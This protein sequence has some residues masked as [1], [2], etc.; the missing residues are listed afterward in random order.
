[1]G[2]ER[3]PV[4]PV[5]KLV[6]PVILGPRIVT[7]KAEIEVTANF[8]GRRFGEAADS[9]SQAVSQVEPVARDHHAVEAMVTEDVDRLLSVAPVL[10]HVRQHSD[11]H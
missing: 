1:M 10:V 8:D 5:S 4:V 2:R 3:V 6:P 11:S 9:L 7:I